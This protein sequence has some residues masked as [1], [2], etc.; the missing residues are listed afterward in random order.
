VNAETSTAE[1]FEDDKEGGLSRSLV[2]EQKEVVRQFFQRFS[3]GDV[4]GTVSLFREDATYWF[5]STRET[6]NMR[7]F[8]RGLEW[9]KS[10]LEGPIRLEIGTMVAEP[11]K[12]AVQVEGFGRT[13]DGAPYNNLYHVYFELEV[14]KIVRAREYNDTAHVFDT[15]RAGE[16]RRAGS[17]A[18]ME[19][20]TVALVSFVKEMTE[21]MT[22][23]ESTK[24]WAKD[25]LWFD[26]PAFASRGVAPASRFF[27]EVFAGFQSCKVEILETDTIVNG[28]IGIVCTVQRVHVVLK[29]GIAKT[30]FIRETDCFEK[31][32]EEWRLIHQHASVPSG[33]EWDGKTVK[34]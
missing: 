9:I 2:E 3:A 10:R 23:A 16:R 5:P 8:A 17:A 26:I 32:D 24:R 22:G 7:Q 25:A 18:S 12:I 33:G 11:N 31:R 29:N 34:E 28:N 14:R 30:M 13:V 1:S 15:L 19:K 21:S 27:D 4:P 6:T 20:D